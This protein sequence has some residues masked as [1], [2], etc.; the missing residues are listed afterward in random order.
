MAR[1]RRISGA[2]ILMVILIIQGAAQQVLVEGQKRATV[3]PELCENVTPASIQDPIDVFALVNE[4]LCKG[5]GDLAADYTYTLKYTTREKG[6]KE[7]VKEAAIIY[8]VYMPALKS[9][10]HAR[11]VLLV[12]H[13]NGKPIPAKE[14]KKER[15]KAG[16]SLEEAEKQMASAPP[17]PSI[18]EID[19]KI[20]MLPLGVYPAVTFQRGFVMI[21]SKTISL[22]VNVFLLRCDLTPIRREIL[23]GRESLLFRFNPRKNAQLSE[24]VKYVQLIDGLIWIDAQDRIV[25]RLMGWPLGMLDSNRTDSIAKVIGMPTA[26]FIELIRTPEGVWLPREARINGLDY[27][28]IFDG[29][30]I[31]QSFSFSEYKRF[32]IEVRDVTVGAPK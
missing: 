10:T 6:E 15:L 12:T 17:S 7:K 16:E 8:E 2:L 11:G 31:E 9:G 14:Q 19:P 1:M 22:N 18:K 13:R 3:I 26:V 21:N 5:A 27:P 30:S 25:T 20:G 29:K 32:V 23:D 28:K 4:A 24:D